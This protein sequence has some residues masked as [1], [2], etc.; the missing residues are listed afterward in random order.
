MS[1]REELRKKLQSVK[2]LSDLSLKDTK[3]IGV[4]LSDLVIKEL[5]EGR[6]VR[7]DRLIIKV[8]VR[9]SRNS[10]NPQ[11]KQK[12]VVPEKRVPQIR[13]VGHKTL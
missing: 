13:I 12:I 2:K 5:K 3:D 7:L 11:T 9:K 6:N 10:I 1:F 4:I 8:K